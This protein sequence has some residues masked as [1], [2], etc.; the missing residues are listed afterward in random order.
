MVPAHRPA[1]DSTALFWFSGSTHFFTLM[2]PP[3]YFRIDHF[4]EAFPY[5]RGG[6]MHTGGT[7]SAC[8]VDQAR[9][10]ML[11]SPPGVSQ[12]KSVSFSH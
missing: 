4:R 12:P 10:W 5:C 8:V 6:G 1:T 11:R 9:E 7:G 3:K 2:Q